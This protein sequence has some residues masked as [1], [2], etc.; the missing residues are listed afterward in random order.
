L[1]S[2]ETRTIVLTPAAEVLVQVKG[3]LAVAELDVGQPLGS[4]VDEAGVEPDGS[5]YYGDDDPA[6]CSI[7][8][9]LNPLLPVS[10]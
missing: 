10:L 7:V 4:D 8:G 2:T 9:F 6:L 5:A 1:R 3:G